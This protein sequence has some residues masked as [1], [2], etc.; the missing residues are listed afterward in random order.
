VEEDIESS[1]DREEDAMDDT[2]TWGQSQDVIRQEIDRLEE[3]IESGT[4]EDTEEAQ[5]RIEVLLGIMNS[6]IPYRLSK[7]EL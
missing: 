1:C 6:C 3:G 4:I 2:L 7:D 5:E